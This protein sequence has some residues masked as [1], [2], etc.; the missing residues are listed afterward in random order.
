MQ[1]FNE[2]CPHCNASLQG[3]PIPEDE[4]KH[5]RATHFTRKIGMYDLEKDRTMKWK[6]PDCNWEW[7]RE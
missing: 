6:C 1:Y 7:D 3:D 5:Y 4:Q 2:K